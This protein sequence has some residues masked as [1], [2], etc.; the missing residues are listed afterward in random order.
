MCLF[1]QGIQPNRDLECD[2][3]RGIFVRLY[4]EREIKS[5]LIAKGEHRGTQVGNQS[6]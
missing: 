6:M 4:V 5:V 3:R 2:L 1:L